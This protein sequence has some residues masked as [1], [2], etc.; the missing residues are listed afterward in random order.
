[1]QMIEGK[2]WSKCSQRPVKL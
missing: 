1:M 2:N